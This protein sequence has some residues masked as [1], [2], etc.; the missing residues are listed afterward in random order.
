MKTFQNVWHNLV[1]CA[2]STGETIV[3]AIG[4]GLGKDD[5]YLCVTCILGLTTE[6]FE[7]RLCW[8]SDIIVA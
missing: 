3:A 5:G 1:L 2:Q 7:G 6:C 4:L 8:Q